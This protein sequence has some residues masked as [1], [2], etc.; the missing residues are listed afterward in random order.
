MGKINLAVFV[1][2]AYA[3]VLPLYCQEKSTG[4][5]TAHVVLYQP[6]DVLVARM[7]SASE[8]AGYVQQLQTILK[9]NYKETRVAQ[10]LDV[11]VGLRPGGK[12]RIWLISSAANRATPELDDLRKQLE[13]VTP[14]SVKGLVALAICGKIY[15]GDPTVKEKVPFQP[16]IPQ[17]WSD[18][19]KDK[20]TSPQPV[21]DVYLDIIWPAT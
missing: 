8:L 3:S 16:P 14:V 12:V 2:L 21:P 19:L 4:F 20:S 5:E 6:N 18:A 7:P 10:N 9:N 15:G 11:V 1:L 17:E 13:S